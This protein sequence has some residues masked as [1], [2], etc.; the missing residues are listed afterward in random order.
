V[1]GPATTAIP[2]P[3]PV[4]TRTGPVRGWVAVPLVVALLVVL[5]GEVAVRAVSSHL[6][7][8]QLWS[9]PESQ[10]KY[11]EM[12]ALA[13]AHQTGGVVLLGTSLTDVGID[14]ALLSGELGAHLPVYDASLAGG[15]LESVRWWYDHVVAPFLQPK[16]VVFGISSRELNPSD[17]Q[18]ATLAEQFFAAPAVRHIDGTE[19]VMQRLERYAGDA[20]YLFRYRKVLRQPSQVVH[21][22]TPIDNQERF[23]TSLGMATPFAAMVYQRS[24]VIDAFFRTTVTANYHVGAAK[25][26]ALGGTLADIRASHA[27]ALLVAM[28][29]T[30]DYIALHPHGAADFGRYEQVMAEVATQVG[31][32]EMPT[33]VWPPALFADPIHLNQAGARRLTPLIARALVPLLPHAAQPRAAP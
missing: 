14:P 17:P 10:I 21:K 1:A 6:P 2:P 30:A 31:V 32:P 20:S 25:V 23:L 24:P 29:I 27:A 4:E 13:R 26:S 5:L 28:P 8:P 22:T 7:E 12:R 18:A 3:A 11:D 15:T 9:S 16:V 19:S 33:Q